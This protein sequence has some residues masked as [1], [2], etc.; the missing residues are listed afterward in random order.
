MTVPAVILHLPHSSAEV[1]AE[2][3]P[4]LLLEDDDLERELRRMTDWHTDELFT[5]PPD[6]A[7]RVRFPV[8][9][10]VVDPE[11]FADPAA[12]RLEAVG[13]GAVPTKTSQGLPLRDEAAATRQRDALLARYYRPHHATLAAAVAA[14][15]EAHGRCL[16]FDCQGF[17]SRPLPYELKAGVDRWSVVHRPAVCIGTDTTLPP[18]APFAHPG[19]HTPPWL[20]ERAAEALGEM[21]AQWPGGAAPDPASAAHEPAP[22]GASQAVAGIAFDRPFA[23]ALVPLPYVGHDRRVQAVMIDVRRDL[24]MNEETGAR[25]A[26][27]AG[28]AAVVRTA[29]QRIIA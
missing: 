10:L 18:H 1:P 20:R 17:P 25:L 7:V 5:L 13:M 4:Q 24:Y 16:I 22:D 28:C 8:S 6:A 21:L 12:E 3:R 9:R 27:F 26:G 23:G 29:L 11:R 15:L 19:M 2:V 14:A